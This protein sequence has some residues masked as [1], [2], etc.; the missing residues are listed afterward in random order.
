MS[1]MP[2]NSG[3]LWGHPQAIR[4]SN[5]P[6]WVER[7]ELHVPMELV[8]AILS[9]KKK[10]KKGETKNCKTLSLSLSL[11]LSISAN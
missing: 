7:G 8:G 11:S 3:S 2:H 10:E 4:P 9:K 6:V 1:S 5:Y